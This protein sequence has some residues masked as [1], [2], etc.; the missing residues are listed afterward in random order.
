MSVQ[1]PNGLLKDP[2]KCGNC[3]GDQFTITN[4]RAPDDHRAGGG[5]C[6][7]A[8]HNETVSDD[9]PHSVIAGCLIVQCLQCSS[10]SVISISIP[11]ITISGN[12]CGGWN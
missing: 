6:R 5:G 1:I 9:N 7:E 3:G 2:M 4:L 12:L 8:V 11:S 10:E